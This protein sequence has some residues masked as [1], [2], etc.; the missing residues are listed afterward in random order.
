[1]ALT[2]SDKK[3]LRNSFLTKNDSKRFT[4]KDDLKSFAT[5]DDLK[6]FA[7]KDDLKS[8]ATKDDLSNLATKADFEKLDRKFDK[9]FDFLDRDLSYFKKKTA[10]YLGVPVSKLQ[11][12]SD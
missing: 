5:K 3:W 8:F 10:H 1:M 6:S 2:K 9:L 7:T 4:T 12:S 11:R